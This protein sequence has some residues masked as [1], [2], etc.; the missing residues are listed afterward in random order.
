M[1][2]SEG[3]TQMAFAVRNANRRHVKELSDAEIEE[4]LQSL[5]ASESFK[6]ALIYERQRRLEKG[7]ESNPKN[8]KAGIWQRN[9]DFSRKE[10]K[11]R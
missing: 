3:V 6:V 8:R 1:D 5:Y 10:G 9:F 11:Q 2:I 4:Y 7:T